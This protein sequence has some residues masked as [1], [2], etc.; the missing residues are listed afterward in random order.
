MIDKNFPFKHPETGETLWYSR[1]CA[2]TGIVLRK[3]N[4]KIS[5]LANK[6]GPGAPDFVGYW[7]MPCGYLDY[8]ETGEEAVKREVQEE[9]GIYTNPKKWKLFGIQTDP[10]ANKQ[11][12][13]IRYI[14]KWAKG[15][16]DKIQNIEGGEVDEVEDVKWIPIED[17]NKYQWAFGH[18][19]IIKHIQ[20]NTSIFKYFVKWV[21]RITKYM[22][23]N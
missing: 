12:V 2:V 19:Q 3:I 20:V 14:Y 1:S 21:R 13:T 4:K 10:K 18:D 11:N 23:I 22:F 5:V 16:I 17:V 15:D 8:N 6:R 9:T 7:N